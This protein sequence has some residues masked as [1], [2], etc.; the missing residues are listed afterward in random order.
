M[1]L[2]VV[3]A[4]AALRFFP[5]ATHTRRIHFSCEA[6]DRFGVAR[7]GVAVAVAG[8][9]VAALMALMAHA[10][11]PVR[12]LEKGVHGRCSVVPSEGVHTAACPAVTTCSALALV[13][14]FAAVAVLAPSEVLTMCWRCA[15][16]L[17]VLA[18]PEVS[19]NGENARANTFSC[20]RACV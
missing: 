11:V 18:P 12:M 14:G 19:K 5:A 17:A 6:G 3:L 2:R 9:V 16:V 1:H 20:V 15:D 13:H 4:A 10:R 8:V 7:V